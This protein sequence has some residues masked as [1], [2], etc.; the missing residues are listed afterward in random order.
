MKKSIEAILA[1]LFVGTTL[2][3]G[4]MTAAVR[5]ESQVNSHLEIAQT[6]KNKGVET[7]EEKKREQQLAALLTPYAK[8]TLEQAKQAALS[9]VNGEEIKEANIDVNKNRSLYYEVEMET[10][11]VYVDAGNGKILG[12][13]TIEQES[14]EANIQSSLKLPNSVNLVFGD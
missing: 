3:L 13:E 4:A 8:I 9:E 5:A 1:S 14:I 11:I 7:S 12:V 2:G 10:R 6:L